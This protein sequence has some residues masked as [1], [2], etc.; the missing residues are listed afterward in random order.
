MKGQLSC[1]EVINGEKLTQA[2]KV[3]EA[4]TINHIDGPYAENVSLKKLILNRGA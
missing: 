4:L 3:N 2:I 1:R